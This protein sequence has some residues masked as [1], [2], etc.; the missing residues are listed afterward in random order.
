MRLKKSD[1]AAKTKPFGPDRVPFKAAE[2]GRVPGT[3]LT[4][5][6]PHLSDLSRGVGRCALSPR[7]KAPLRLDSSA[8]DPGLGLTSALV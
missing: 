3:S 5:L 4:P 6:A 2:P 1:S 7:G 8:A